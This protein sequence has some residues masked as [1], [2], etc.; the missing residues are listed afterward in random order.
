MSAVADPP[1]LL[2]TRPEEASRRF[3]A[4]LAGE[5]PNGVRAVIAPLLE[6]EVISGPI[7]PQ[8]TLILTSQNAV[9]ALAEGSDQ[10]V[11]C[12]GPRTAEAAERAG[13]TVL[14][15]A[16]TAEILLADIVAANARGPLLH[17]RG[18]KVA[19]PLAEKLTQAGIETIES[20][21]Y[22]QKRLPLTQ[23]A[24]DLLA[25]GARVVVPLFSPESARAFLAEIEGLPVRP[26][27]VAIS[28]AVA[29]ICRVSGV[30]VVRVAETPDGTAMKSAV[31]CQLAA[32][33]PG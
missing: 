23:E 16:P 17:L 3:A 7:A 20:V 32:P 8:Q 10:A 28:E 9:R 31:L 30:A 33:M 1:V 18:D 27:I 4:G 12:V 24:R 5:L 2:L 14:G 22:R 13:L 29:R 26:E 19:F 15:V 21:V 25:E 11:W 6:I